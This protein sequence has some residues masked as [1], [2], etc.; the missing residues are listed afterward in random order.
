MTFYDLGDTVPLT[1]EVVDAGGELTAASGVVCTVVLPD[2]TTETPSAANPSTGRYTVDYVPAQVGRHVY[3]WTSTAPAAARSDEF[4]VRPAY[5]A[6][7][8]SLDVAKA[9]LNKTTDEADEEIRS[10]LEVT[11]E[12]VEELAGKA[13]AR[14]TVVERC[15]LD[16]WTDGLALTWTPVLSLTSVASLDG[17]TTWTVGSLDVDPASGIVRVLTGPS[18]SGTLI[19][20]YQAGYT[21]V[22]ARYT[23]A[24]RMILRHLWETQRAG[25]GGKRSRSGIVDDSMQLVAGYAIPRAAA[26]LIG[27]R[28]PL[29]A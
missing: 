26:D 7:I 20:T 24:A 2:G 6:Y 23:G 5:P 13:T 9:H 16:C 19:V 25:L 4:D 3:R 17:S 21:S 29:V 28:G 8:I 22:P 1:T 11:T 18:L 15:A 14:R 12:I 10:W 27:P